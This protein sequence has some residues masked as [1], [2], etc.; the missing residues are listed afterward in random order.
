M[1]CVN[2]LEVRQP[3]TGVLQGL[4][5]FKVVDIHGPYHEKTVTLYNVNSKDTDQP[6]HLYSLISTFA[7]RLL[8]RI[9]SKLA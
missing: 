6:V 1:G 8:E 9:A 4:S 5:L 7:I 2:K 3:F